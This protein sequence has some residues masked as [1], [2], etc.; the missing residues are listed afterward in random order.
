M[1]IMLSVSKSLDSRKVQT[2]S[3]SDYS[4]SDALTG[5]LRILTLFFSGVLF[6]IVAPLY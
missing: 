6:I 1:T 3:V 4:V 5:M 2:C